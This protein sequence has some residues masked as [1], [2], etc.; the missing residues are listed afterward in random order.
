MESQLRTYWSTPERAPT[1]TSARRPAVGIATTYAH[2]LVVLTEREAAVLALTA[3]GLSN[4]EIAL[5]CTWV[6]TVE[7]QVGTFTK[8]DI[9]ADADEHRRVKAV[10][11]Y[12]GANSR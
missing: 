12:L 9:T 4:G 1:F 2:P 8:L 10:L 3:E 5:V 7:T 11:A 6:R